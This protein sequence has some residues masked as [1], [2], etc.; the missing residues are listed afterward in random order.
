MPTKVF[1]LEPT[2]RQR[3]S[4]R[5]Y[6]RSRW[7]NEN[8]RSVYDNPCPVSGA[9]HDAETAIED[10]DV[11]RTEEGYVYS[12]AWPHE[13]P[14]WPAHCQCGYAFV[15]DDQWQLFVSEIYRRSDTGEEMT[16]RESPP[17][18]MWW[19]PWMG[20]RWHPQLGQL[21]TIK[22][23]DGTGWMPDM[24]ANNCTMP[25]DADQERHHCWVVKGVPPNLTVSKDGPTCA[26]GAG[27]IQSTNYHGFLQDG[28]LTDGC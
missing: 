28:Y 1:L 19:C 26:A 4:L 14:R 18:A 20:D 13:D 2:E 7:D 17:G 11:T 27:S 22:L 24:Q 12:G 10:G 3:Q 16:L 5:R 15:E 9:S 8:N 23:P 21:F 6:T 25:D